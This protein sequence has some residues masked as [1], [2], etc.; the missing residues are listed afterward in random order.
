MSSQPVDRLHPVVEFAHRLT[1]R[2]DALAT[3]PVWSMSAADQRDALLELTRGQAQLE[4]LK[5]R[6]LAEADRSEATTESGAGSAADW[7]SVK[8]RQVRRDAK[9]DL[10]LATAL[11][12]H[13]VLSAAMAQGRVNIAQARAIVA[14]LDRLPNTGEFA[15]SDE[16]RHGVEL[17]LVAQAGHH[18]AKALRILG[19]RIFEVTAP[20]LAEQFEGRALEA[21]EALALRRTT[22]TMREDD[23]GTCHGRFRI[24]ALH[25]QMLTKMILALASPVR[26]GSDTTSGIDPDLPTPVRHGLALTQLLETYPAQALPKAGGCSATV[27]VTM[28]LEQL[29]ADLDEAGVCTLDTGGR[30]SAGQ[31]RRLACTAGI[32]PVVL[33]GKSQVLDVGRRRRLH[34]EPM[35]IAMSFRDRGCTTEGCETPPGMCHA[36]HET[37]WSEGGSTNLETGRLLCPHHHRRIHDPKYETQR[38]PDGKVSFHRRT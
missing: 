36:H 32:V 37:P 16:Q 24:P 14:S 38:M 22:L 27:V 30:L 9:S 33:G 13:D 3:T 29:T 11:E 12:Q 4:A 21:E 8:T 20:D 23:E 6:L 17:H 34:T 35:R 15:V 7:V 31:A 1:E 2:L 25:G 5:L 18:D 28:T 10:K 19:L 26:S